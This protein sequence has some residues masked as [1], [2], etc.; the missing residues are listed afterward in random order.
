[1]RK[2]A[3]QPWLFS[4]LLLTGCVANNGD[5]GLTG[6]CFYVSP[7]E[8]KDYCGTTMIE[9]IA[10]PS[11]F[12]GQLVTVRGWVIREGEMIVL[13]PFSEYAERGFSNSSIIV[14]GHAIDDLSQSLPQSSVG[15]APQRI[16]VSGRF[17][18]LRGRQTS[19]DVPRLG[20][21]EDVASTMP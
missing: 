10:R 1:M 13:F 7:V 18:S 5:D 8:G 6:H 3:L 20:F 16:T 12:D 15:V 9:I 11:L 19:S 14:S 21:L 4:F 17:N 2:L